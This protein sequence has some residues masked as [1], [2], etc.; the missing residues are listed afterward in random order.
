MKKHHILLIHFF[1]VASIYIPLYPNQAFQEAFNKG[2]NFFRNNDYN[3]ALEWLDQAIALDPSP[4]QTYFNAGLV[5][6]AQEQHEKA[7]NYLE[8]AVKRNNNYTKAR[9]HLAQTYHTL[10]RY[11]DA[12]AEYTKLCDTEQSADLHLNIAR[13]YRSKNKSDQAI[14]H[15]TRALQL[16][17]KNINALF[18]IS[19]VYTISGNYHTAIPYYEKLLTTNPDLI[20]AACNFAHTLKYLGQY[21]RAVQ[22]YTQVVKAWPNFA[23]GHYGLAECCLALGDFERG[24]KA[25][26]W[27]WKRDGNSRN[28]SKKLWDGSPIKGKTILLRAE[29]GQ[30]DTMQFIRYA[31]KLKEQGA[32]IILEAQETLVTLLSQCPYLDDVVPVMNSVD[33]LPHFDFQIPVMSFPYYFNTTIDTVP[34]DIPYL[35]A[36]TQLVELWKNELKNDK[37]LKIG[38]CWGTSPYYEQFKSAF[39]KKAIPLKSFLP[40]A[41]LTEVSLYSLQKMDGIEQ[42]NELPRGMHIHTFDADF[43][44]S[45]GRF[46]D[47]AA[48][49]ENLDL[50]ITVDTSVAHLAGALGKPVL[51]I[52]PIVADWRWMIDRNDTPWYQQMKLYRQTE[53]GKWDNVL[54]TISKDI[55]A[56]LHKRTKKTVAPISILAEVQ[57]GELIDK[58]TILQI[59]KE[60]IKDPAKLINIE[61]ELS[62]LLATCNHHIPQSPMLAK[63]WDELLKVNETL[64]VI[65]DD[66]RD[67]ERARTFDHTFVKLARDVYHTNDERCRIKRELN[68]L[69][70]SRLIE[71]KSYTDYTITT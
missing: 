40:I 33:D 42:L 70:G 10:N 63:L 26:E 50:V 9:L 56:L 21:Q 69:T 30:G 68:L 47:T 36:D 1:L 22:Y 44:M 27:R 41:Q 64:W 55:A 54:C 24:W 15:Y 19:H 3:Q 7:C 46:M 32:M 20:D 8:I 23:D 5:C 57:V 39:S 29:Y 51:M 43:D 65:E 16:D 12:L 18:E 2:I 53:V 66:I 34:D 28:F 71:E 61:A 45:H 25:F 60:R 13:L 62:T 49:I 37:N 11:D 6:L 58:I 38:I 4:E 35:H 67:K 59:K 52:L 17:P 14:D 31:K 48:V